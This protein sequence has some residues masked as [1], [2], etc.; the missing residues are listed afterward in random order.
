[1]SD[2][3]I[4]D[5]PQWIHHEPENAPFGRVDGHWTAQ[6]TLFA[7]ELLPGLE[8]AASVYNLLEE[9]I[10]HPISEEHPGDAMTQPGRT[11]RFKLTS[12]F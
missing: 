7:H 6:V 4:R 3:V 12:K 2:F 1:M 5:L 8:A 11:F 9:S 10:D